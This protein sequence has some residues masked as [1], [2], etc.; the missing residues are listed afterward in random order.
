MDQLC[1][2]I[3]PVEFYIFTMKIPIRKD[4][5]FTDYYLSQNLI[6]LVVLSSF[7]HLFC[8]KFISS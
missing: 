2:K 3:F 5:V 7:E 6:P 1:C 4:S 8:Q